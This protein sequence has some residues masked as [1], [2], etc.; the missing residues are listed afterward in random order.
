MLHSSSK[1]RA[2]SYYTAI[3]GSEKENL[4]EKETRK[5]GIHQ[6]IREEMDETIPYDPESS[7]RPPRT[8]HEGIFIHSLTHSLTHSFI[9][10]FIL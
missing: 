2:G 10:A 8:D 6:G 4:E 5:K 9:H 3:E 1:V 7:A